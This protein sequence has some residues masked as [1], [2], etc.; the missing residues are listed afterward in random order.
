MRSPLRQLAKKLLSPTRPW[1]QD[2]ADHRYFYIDLVKSLGS[3]KLYGGDKPLVLDPDLLGKRSREETP[4]EDSY[5]EERRPDG[6]IRLWLF[7]AN[8]VD[9]LEVD[10][11]RYEGE[12]SSPAAPDT[13]SGAIPKVTLFSSVASDRHY[14]FAANARLLAM[15]V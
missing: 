5:T 10:R 3:R 12:D 14:L 1:T 7:S 4:D 6:T 8:S 15:G 13:A 11:M 9:E 2:P